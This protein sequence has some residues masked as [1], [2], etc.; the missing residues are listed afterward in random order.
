MGRQGLHPGR[1]GLDRFSVQQRLISSVHQTSESRKR[2]KQSIAGR[3]AARRYKTKRKAIQKQKLDALK[4][5]TPCADCGNYFPAVCM[6][7]DHLPG[8]AK[9]A[10]LS[11]LVKRIITSS[12]IDAEIAKCELVC[13]N[14]HRIRTRNRQHEGR[15]NLR[16]GTE[17]FQDPTA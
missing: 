16:H 6:D 5:A 2:Y 7:F 13:A 11:S 17:P 12:V 8:Q 10:E 1:A 14:C 9:L 4:E 3:L 15:Q